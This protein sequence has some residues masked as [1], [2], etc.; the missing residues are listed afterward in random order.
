M[1][2][3]R[4]QSQNPMPG[5]QEAYLQQQFLQQHQPPVAGP[6][7]QSRRPSFSAS[8]WQAQQ[9]QP[10]TPS[11]PQSGIVWPSPNQSTQLNRA[12]TFNGGRTNTVR[13]PGTMA[14]TDEFSDIETRVRMATQKGD[15]SL[16]GYISAAEERGRERQ[17]RISG[18]ML[19]LTSRSR[20]RAPEGGAMGHGVMDPN[21]IQNVWENA[22]QRQRKISTA[23]RPAYFPQAGGVNMG[24]YQQ[25][26]IP[27][28]PSPNMQPGH[29][30]RVPVKESA[31]PWEQNTRIIPGGRPQHDDDDD[32]DDDYDDNG[33]NNDWGEWH[34][35]SSAPSQMPQARTP[36]MQHQ[37]TPLRHPVAIQQQQ[38]QQVQFAT[39]PS[40]N[41]ATQ[42]MWPSQSPMIPVQ[43]QLAGGVIPSPMAGAGAFLPQPSPNRSQYIQM[44]AN[45]ISGHPSP[46]IQSNVMQGGVYPP[47]HILA[48]KPVAASAPSTSFTKTP[49]HAAQP[50]KTPAVNAQSFPAQ[51]TILG[52]QLAAKLNQV[53]LSQAQPVPV[54]GGF[55][56]PENVRTAIARGQLPPGIPQPQQQQQSYGLPQPPQ[57][58]PVPTGGGA[59]TLTSTGGIIPG[60]YSAPQPQ[61]HEAQHQRVKYHQ[62]QPPPGRMD[63]YQSYDGSSSGASPNPSAGRGGAE[64]D[65]E[66]L[67]PPKGYQQHQHQHPRHEQRLQQL[68]RQQQHQ[69]QVRQTQHGP[70]FTPQGRFDPF[71]AIF[72][73][74]APG[75]FPRL[76]RTLGEMR[77]THQ[78]WTAFIQARV[79]SPSVFLV[80]DCLITLNTSGGPRHLARPKPAAWKVRSCSSPSV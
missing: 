50:L 13:M 11:Q 14:G 33:D 77:V 61:P 22:Q 39:Q 44:P 2:H 23:E 43:S 16:D 40:P 75:E 19:G 74:N 10:F 32:D 64:S 21:R 48:G 60:G 30:R 63:P 8:P 71:I 3:S 53:Q 52:D 46:M 24:Q 49:A 55:V 79:Y 65:L 35:Q 36:Y 47:G 31:K 6:S 66:L 38:P 41:T 69:Q 29:V 70:R 76:P 58:V 5:Y 18:S 54:A 25:G 51:G 26:V 42:Q 45:G 7:N 12:N 59:G 67:Q 78:E 34:K 68:Q 4:S 62:G 20:S 37:K 27:Q 1:K 56:I 9:Q 17:R 57:L 80:T 28:Q 73:L 15:K 72:D